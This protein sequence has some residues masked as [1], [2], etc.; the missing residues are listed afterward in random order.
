METAIQYGTDA[1][2]WTLIVQAAEAFGTPPWEIV[3]A[4]GGLWWLARWH[5]LRQK[6]YEKE[7]DDLEALRNG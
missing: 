4:P 2:F 5:R 6:Q 7:Q 3:D 1:P